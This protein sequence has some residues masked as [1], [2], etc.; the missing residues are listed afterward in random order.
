MIIEL[1]SVHSNHYQDRKW[2]VIC[3]NIAHP[4][5][6]SYMGLFVWSYYVNDLGKQMDFQC[7]QGN[8]ITGIGSAHNNRPHDRRYKF[9]CTYVANWKRGNCQWSL[10]TTLD[11]AW[12]RHTPSGKF[13]VGVK[14]EFDKSKK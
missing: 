4:Y 8:V 13:L 9:R 1:R 6:A 7:P 10:Y 2:K 12:N 3:E 14:S 11:A 5:Y